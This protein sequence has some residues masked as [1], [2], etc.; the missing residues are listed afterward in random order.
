MGGWDVDVGLAVPAVLGGLSVWAPRICHMD[1][2]LSRNKMWDGGEGTHTTSSS[3]ACFASLEHHEASDAVAFA[4]AA[5]K[6]LP[7]C[8]CASDTTADN[9]HIGVRRQLFGASEAE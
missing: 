3:P 4:V 2:I 6:E 9:N 8:E 7:C 5:F 1:K